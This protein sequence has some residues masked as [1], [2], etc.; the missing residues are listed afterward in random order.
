MIF[1]IKYIQKY[2][3]CP[4]ICLMIENYQ[5][6][7][8]GTT[9]QQVLE[10]EPFFLKFLKKKKIP[11]NIFPISSYSIQYNISS[12]EHKC[13]GLNTNSSVRIRKYTF[14]TSVFLTS[15]TRA[16]DSSF[17]N[18]WS[19]YYCTGRT[20]VPRSQMHWCGEK[21]PGISFDNSYSVKQE[22]FNNFFFSKFS[23][24]L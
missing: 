24:V 2:I 8:V 17:E 20:S 4:I 21:N 6:I 1:N 3:C 10:F 9:T 23:Q 22:I 13:N 16:N 7:G 12:L 11:G 19:E 15:A 18:R 14:L 5:L